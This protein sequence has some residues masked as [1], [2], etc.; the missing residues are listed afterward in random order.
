MGEEARLIL[1]GAEFL[2]AATQWAWSLLRSGKALLVVLIIFLRI[3]L[4]Y[5]VNSRNGADHL[6]P[7]TGPRR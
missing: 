4:L 6:V 5:T 1:T 2:F 3:H 7:A